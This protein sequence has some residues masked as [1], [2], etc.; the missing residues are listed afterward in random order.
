VPLRALFVLFVLAAALSLPARSD[1]AGSARVAA[2]QVALKA[3]G[4]YAGPVDGLAGPATH[5]A[6]KSF[7]RHRHLTV[8][9]VP[10]A[11]TRRA[12]GRLGRHPLGS[13]PLGPGNVGWDVAALQFL[14]AEHG[15]PSGQFDGGFGGRTEAAVRRFQRWARLSVDGRVGPAT[16][17]ALARSPATS[18]IRLAWPLQAQ[19][20]DGFGPRGAGFHAGLDLPADTGRGVAAAG[21]GRVSWAGWRDGGWGYLVVIAHRGG[22]RSMYAHLS[23]VDV[24]VGERVSAGFQ[25]GLIGSTGHSTGPHLHFELRLRGAAIDPLTAL[26]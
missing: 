21:P 11:R 26:H 22:V 2:L 6:I 25:I 16:I 1:A 17:S 18:P 20:G 24:R 14:L 8:D 7:Q 4:L 23:R 10:G 19:T 12:L 9:G 15:F 13:R 3:H 5:H